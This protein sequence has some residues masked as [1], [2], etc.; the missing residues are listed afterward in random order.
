MPVKE[1]PQPAREHPEVELTHSS[2]GA[3]A[4]RRGDRER[5]VGAWVCGWAD[6]WRDG[7]MLRRME[8]DGW[9][10]GWLGGQVDEW[11]NDGSMDEWM[12]RRMD[13]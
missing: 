10:N 1:C 11:T 7:G 12:D 6:E 2:L 8:G 13:R 5:G 4:P 9:L 3:Q